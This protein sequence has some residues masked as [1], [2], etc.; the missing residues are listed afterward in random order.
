LAFSML[1]AVGLF[2]VLPAA[3]FTFLKLHFLTWPVIGLNLCEGLFRIS[4]F[5]IFL[6]STQFM[7]DMRRVYAFHGAEH[8]AVNTYEAG[9]PL[10][11]E[12]VRKYTR[13]HIRC[14]TAFIMLVLVVSI[15]VFSLLGK[16]GLFLRIGL[17]LVL[18]PLIAGISYELTRLAAGKPKFWLFQVLLFPGLLMQKLTTRE[19]DDQQIKAAIAALKEVV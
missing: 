15:L 2:I 19:P 5:L 11:V 6:A 1:L 12:N 4:L 7:A 10:T 13:I 3:F 18:L 17:K 9:Q 8:K 14:G 16:P